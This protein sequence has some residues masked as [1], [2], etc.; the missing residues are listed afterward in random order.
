MAKSNIILGLSSLQQD[1]CAGF[2]K[3]TTLARLNLWV[4]GLG[5]NADWLGLLYAC[6]M[7]YALKAE[8]A[9]L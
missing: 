2:P 3:Q 5:Q 4:G 8:V 9:L 6:E 7:I 1:C